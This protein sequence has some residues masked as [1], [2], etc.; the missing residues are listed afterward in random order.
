[1]P[2]LRISAQRRPRSKP[3]L[4]T[5]LLS[6]ET[7]SAL[8]ATEPQPKSALERSPSPDV[9]WIVA[10]MLSAF[11]G[12]GVLYGGGG[13][14]WNDVIDAFGVSEG[15]FGVASGVGLVFSFPVL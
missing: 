13:V 6:I 2:W 11:V 7:T 10:F 14:L 15:A 12:L 5:D 8:P 3:T 9:L 1:M 4:R